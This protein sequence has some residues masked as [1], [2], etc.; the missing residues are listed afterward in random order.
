[1]ETE[2]SCITLITK[3]TR[4]TCSS[5]IIKCFVLKEY[6]EHYFLEKTFSI[7]TTFKTSS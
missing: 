4:N 2:K 3:E 1:M 5:D 7:R 6:I